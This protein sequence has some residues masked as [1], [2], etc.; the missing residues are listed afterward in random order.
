M[1]QFVV[2]IVSSRFLENLLTCSYFVMRT[3]TM[4]GFSIKLGEC[5]KGLKTI[6]LLDIWLPLVKR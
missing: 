6:L 5:W 2:L 4:L 1:G 3:A